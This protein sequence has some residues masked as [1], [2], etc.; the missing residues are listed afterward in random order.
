MGAGC[1]AGCASGGA[2]A[3]VPD[4]TL[5]PQ[6]AVSRGPM[7]PRGNSSRTSSGP[8]ISVTACNL[9]PAAGVACGRKFGGSLVETRARGAT[10]RTTYRTRIA[11][12]TRSMRKRRAILPSRLPVW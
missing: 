9:V 7:F 3:N 6:A 12:V 11:P 4:R 5:S 1:R 8:H 2:C 10:P